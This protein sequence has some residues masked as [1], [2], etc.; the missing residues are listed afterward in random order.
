[1]METNTKF[2]QIRGK[3]E[4][5]KDYKIGDDV[6]VIVT[7]TATEIRDEND[8]NYTKIFKGRIFEIK[9]EE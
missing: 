1:M 2:I 9:E 6:N 3:L 4:T 7:I 8:G 5:E